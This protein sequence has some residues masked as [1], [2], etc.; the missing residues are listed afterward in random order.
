MLTASFDAVYLGFPEPQRPT[1][2]KMLPLHNP[3]AIERLNPTKTVAVDRKCD[4]SRFVMDDTYLM[5]VTTEVH[6]GR[7]KRQEIVGS[8]LR[9][10][11]TTFGTYVVKP[12]M[13][14]ARGKYKRQSIHGHVVMI[15]DTM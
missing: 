2:F 13:S 14:V 1:P 5:D 4:V 15:V 8:N 11:V 9:R 7:I 6:L 12:N 3:P 10:I